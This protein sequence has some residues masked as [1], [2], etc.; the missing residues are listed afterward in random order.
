MTWASDPFC[1]RVAVALAQIVDHNNLRPLANKQI[2]EM[3]ADIAGTASDQKAIHQEG[4]FQ[5]SREGEK[6]ALSRNCV[7]RVCRGG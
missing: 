3:T 4:S 7:L 2:N 5:Y 1:S 6:D